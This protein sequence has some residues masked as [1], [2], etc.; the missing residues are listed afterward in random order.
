MLVMLVMLLLF[1]LFAFFL[2]ACDVIEKRL[3][4]CLLERLVRQKRMTCWPGHSSLAE[5]LNR[6]LLLLKLSFL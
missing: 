1:L 5:M 6:L 3:A 4:D 2:L